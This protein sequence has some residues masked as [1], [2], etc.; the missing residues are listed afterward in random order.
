VPPQADDQLRLDDGET[1]TARFRVDAGDSTPGSYEIT[2][3]VSYTFAGTTHVRP[4][5]VKVVISS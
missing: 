2:T 4:G 3:E 5:I 1:D